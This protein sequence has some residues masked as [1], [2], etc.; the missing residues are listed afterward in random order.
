MFDRNAD[1]FQ[2]DVG[3]YSNINSVSDQQWLQN[4][5]QTVQQFG[6]S[7]NHHSFLNCTQVLLIFRVMSTITATP[8]PSCPVTIYFDV[9]IAIQIFLKWM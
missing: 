8:L 5:F 7:D 4:L 1:N 2:D 6:V 3:E 9:R